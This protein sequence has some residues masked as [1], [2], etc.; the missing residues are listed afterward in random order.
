MSGKWSAAWLPVVLMLGF[1]GIW[2][3]QHDIDGQMAALHQEQDDL[4]LRSGP[5]LKAMSLEY[6]P[7]VADLYWTRVVQYYGDKHARHDADIQLLWPLLDVTTTLDPNLIVAYRFG[8]MFLSEPAPRG[9]GRPDQA[10]QLLERGIQ[11]NPDYWRFYQDLGFIYYLD[12][13]DYAKASA[14]FLKGSQVPGAMIWMKVM[15]ARVA[16]QGETRETSI[17]LWT[18]I[19][20]S[21]TSPEIKQNAKV[22]LQL[23]RAEEDCERLNALAAEY[24]KLAGHAPGSMSDLVIM[25]LLPFPPADPLGFVYRFDEQGKADLNPASPLF[26]DR[27]KYQK[28]F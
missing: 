4:V 13:K 14:A 12:L 3:L 6:A 8:S 22:H 18:E 15:A 11:A 23:I 21:S 17:F 24:Q 27:P 20:N 28:S 26:A 19:Y 10:I 16:E 2:N 25:G 7:L 9:A 1:G 5:L